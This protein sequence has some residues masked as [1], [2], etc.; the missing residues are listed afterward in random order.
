MCKAIDKNSV[1]CLPTYPRKLAFWLLLSK[2]WAGV[3]VYL[4][5]LDSLPPPGVAPSWVILPPTLNH[6]Y[7]NT[8]CKFYIVFFVSQL[9]WAV[10]NSSRL[11]QNQDFGETALYWLLCT[12]L[13]LLWTCIIMGIFTHNQDTAT[14]LRMMKISY[15]PVIF[16]LFTLISHKKNTL[17]DGWGATYPSWFILP[18]TQIFDQQWLAMDFVIAVNCLNNYKQICFIKYRHC[19]RVCR[20][21]FLKFIHLLLV[22]G[23]GGGNITWLV[24]LTPH[25]RFWNGDCLHIMKW[26]WS[27]TLLK[28]MK[29]SYNSN[30]F[31]LFTL[32][33]HLK[34][35]W[36]RVG[37][38][39]SKLVYL[40][41]QQD[42]WAVIGYGF[43]IAVNCFNNYKWICSTKYWY[44][45]LVYKNQ[46]LEIQPYTGGGQ[47]IMFT[48]PPTHNFG[49]VTVYR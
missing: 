25:P 9:I 36:W 18:P 6:N 43:W 13:H 30:I 35:L 5:P 34:Y 12:S 39:L 48:L 46:F 49:T 11:C 47:H 24:Y 3:T 19:L 28:M 41:P 26:L 23:G 40:A 27:I 29:I 1:C 45:L 42:F 33:S 2:F 17:D 15:H 31:C 16:C 22:G 14:L 20:T 10:A 8:V 32:I 38:N 37:G 4:A 44:C 21:H 7:A